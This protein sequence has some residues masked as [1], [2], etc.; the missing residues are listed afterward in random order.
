MVSI[1]RV[2]LLILCPQD[3]AAGPDRRHPA[4]QQRFGRADRLIAD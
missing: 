1:W 4:D 2:K 3:V